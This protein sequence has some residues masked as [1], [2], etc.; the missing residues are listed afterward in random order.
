MP[1]DGQTASFFLTFANSTDAAAFLNGLQFAGQDIGGLTD[2]CGSSKFVFSRTGTPT[3]ASSN[4]SLAGTCSG[5]TTVPE[6]SS[7]ALL[8]TGLAGV[9]PVIRRRRAS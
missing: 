1:A 2:A 8:G 5:H 4:P 3:T 6:P 7:Q 9:I